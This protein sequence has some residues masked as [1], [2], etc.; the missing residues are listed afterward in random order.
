[1][2]VLNLRQ[3]QIPREAVY[4]GRLSKGRSPWGN[5]FMIGRDGNREQVI[6]AYRQK[7][8][9]DIESG[10]IPLERLAAL[11][12][13]DLVCFCAPQACHGHVLEA[14]AAWAKEILSFDLEALP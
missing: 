1:M 4:I 14:A 3:D 13:K 7:L 6:E 5:P 12:D 8:Y 11:A 2:T 10:A 9:A